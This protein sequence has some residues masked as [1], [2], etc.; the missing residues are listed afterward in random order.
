M[1][2]SEAARPLSILAQPADHHER[3]NV[4]SWKTLS[5]R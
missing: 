5:L 2:L 4:R 1:T 3:M